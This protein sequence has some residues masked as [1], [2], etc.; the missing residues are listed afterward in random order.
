MD[1]NELD[2]TSKQK[3]LVAARKIFI[4]DGFSGARMQDIANEAGINKALLHYYYKNKESLFELVFHDAFAE[5]IPRLHAIFTKEGSVMEKLERYVEAHLA[6]LTEKP[7]LPLFV[8]NEI[9]RDP[10]RFFQNFMSR[11]PGEPPFSALLQQIAEE[12]RQGLLRPMHPREVL[13]NV[14]SLTVFPFVSRPMLQRLTL[15]SDREYSDLMQ[16][17]KET[18]VTFIKQALLVSPQP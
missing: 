14:I 17:R 6:L 4:Q 2:T 16:Q 8:M 5:F 15:M 13:L 9:N 7:F 12:M 10:D 18:I 11:M 3:I 1:K